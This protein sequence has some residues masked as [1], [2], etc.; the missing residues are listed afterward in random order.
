VLIDS[1]LECWGVSDPGC[2]ELEYSTDVEDVCIA[3]DRAGTGMAAEDAAMAD[4]VDKESNDK[5]D[6]AKAVKN[7]RIFYYQF[8]VKVKTLLWRMS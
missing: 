1:F 6:L 8:W 5:D 4:M 2:G 7:W 3:M